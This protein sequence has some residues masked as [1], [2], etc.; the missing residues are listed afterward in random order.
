[1]IALKFRPSI[2]R[3]IVRY[4]TNRVRQLANI[5]LVYYKS[6]DWK[7]V[8]KWSFYVNDELRSEIKMSHD[9]KRDTAEIDFFYF[10]P[11]SSVQI[12]RN[13]KNNS[14]LSYGKFSTVR[15]KSSFSVDGAYIFRKLKYS[16]MDFIRKICGT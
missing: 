7:Y 16:L 4:I 3:R 11:C 5:R 10:S 2:V 8:L 9:T 6:L 14:C 13:S 1:M 12:N 15:C